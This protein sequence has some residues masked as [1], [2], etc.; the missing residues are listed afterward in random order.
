MTSEH[1]GLRVEH[2]GPVL[3]VTLANPAQLNAQTPSLW[4]S[5]AEV[6][7]SLPAEVRVV[8]L[9]ADGRAFSAGLNRAMFASPPALA[10]EPDIFAAARAGADAVA[11]LIAPMQQGFAVWRRVS[12]IVIAAVQGHAIGAGFQLALAADLR[13]VADDVQFAMRE[14]SLGLIP[15]LGGTAPLVRLV[16]YSRA[17]ELCAT[18]RTVGAAEAMRLGLANLAVPAQ[19]LP[20]AVDDLVAALLAAPEPALRALKPLLQQ[21]DQHDLEQQ[22][23]AERRAQGPLLVGLAGANRR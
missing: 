23:A 21:A 10:G 18:G 2:A 7:D 14:V 16:G 20:A 6:G 13:V 22:L 17:L 11:D 4:Y 3:R 8:V 9:Q 1:P 12:A 19:E 15:D 5:L